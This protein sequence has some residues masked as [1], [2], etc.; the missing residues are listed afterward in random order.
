MKDR[1]LITVLAAWAQGKR[2]DELVFDFDDEYA[3]ETFNSDI[4]LSLKEEL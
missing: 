4:R 3:D 2:P 1:L